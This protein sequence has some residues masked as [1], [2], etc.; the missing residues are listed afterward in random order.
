MKGRRRKQISAIQPSTVAA[1]SAPFKQNGPRKVTAVAG[2]ISVTI[3]V[4][5]IDQ[6]KVGLKQ[7]IHYQRHKGFV[8]QNLL[9]YILL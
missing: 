8:L 9:Q 6:Q 4:G 2:G 3:V 5:S 1:A 7:R